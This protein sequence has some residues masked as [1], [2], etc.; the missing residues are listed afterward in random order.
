M[1]FP[2]LLNEYISELN[3]TASELAE[4]SG[5]TSASLSR[6]RNGQRIPE[7]DT[8]RK[9]AAGITDI[10]KKIGQTDITYDCVFSRFMEELC[11]VDADNT[12]F[13]CN[14]EKLVNALQINLNE[15]AKIMG[16]DP[17]YLSRIKKGQRIPAD[18]NKFAEVLSHFLMRK[19]SGSEDTDHICKLIGYTPEGDTPV[20]TDFTAAVINYLCSSE[21][22]ENTKDGIGNYLKKLDEFDLNEYITIIK[23]DKLKVPTAP[24]SLPSSKKI[25][26][27][28]SR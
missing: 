3:C 6:Y 16:Y 26:M 1:T 18:I 2:E 22:P 27:A 8:L 25:I 24:F 13:S 9:L 17:S 15:L 19:Y 23:F 14:F 11:V 21:T 4:A 7:A 20:H 28:L 5:L 12:Q 10:A